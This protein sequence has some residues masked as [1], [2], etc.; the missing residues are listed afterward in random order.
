MK[1]LFSLILILMLCFH[2]F[3]GC[4]SSDSEQ[5]TKEDSS[6]TQISFA[7]SDDEMFTERDYN[8][9]YTESDCVL[10][11]LKTDS[12][13][14]SSD[15]VKISGTTITITEEAT[16]LISGSLSDGMIIIDTED[17]AK[18]HLIFN[19]VSINS[20]TSAALYVLEAEKVVVTLAPD[21]DN[22]LS[23][24]GEFT[25]ID[26]NNIDAVV[27][28][29]Q[30]LSFNGSGS[31]TITSPS[32]HGIVC[33]D[34]LVFTS[35]TYSITASSHG[36]DANDSIRIVNSNIDIEA[37]KDGIHSENDEDENLGFIYISS[38][39]LNISAEG[40]GLSAG[41]FMQ[42]VDGS[43]NVV[44][45]GGSKNA[46]TDT[47][48]SWGMH[49]GPGGPG[50][51]GGPG[52]RSQ[53]YGG[54]T[55]D[56]SE[57]TT[58][59][60]EDS[61][62][63]KGIKASGN[64]LISNGDISIDSADDSIHANTSITVNGGTFNL[65]S[66]D[67]GFHADESLTITAG[68]ININKSYE[69]L[70]AL[71]L[72]ISGGN[73]NLLASDDGLN[74]AGGTDSSGTGGPRG[75]DRFGG[76]SSS[77]GS[78]TISGGTLYVNASGDGL[79]ANGTLTISGGYTTVVGPTS[80][81]TA[82]LD[83]DTSAVIS[84]GTFIGTGSSMMAQSFSQADQGLVAISVGNQAANTNIKLVDSKNNTIIDYSPE[85]SF[86]VIILSSP[87]IISGDSYTITVGE[88]S[89]NIQAY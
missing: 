8:S 11:D 50:G 25:A 14:S 68:D 60:E 22:V 34:D 27:F 77:N 26:D 73:I 35:G 31:L 10:I 21:T 32:G 80:G 15:S 56:S 58:D 55:P 46:T 64:I 19:D 39:K 72:T 18:P 2:L 69:G 70:E 52:D 62:S 75:G 51:H 44:S 28:A 81:D 30:D 47:S 40:D 88:Y 17:T 48:S 53:G 83:Y 9:D 7:K 86:Q 38:G 89:E 85:L 66:G 16:Y 12:A 57:N 78:I 3:A 42:I 20:K 63:I 87:D 79:D 36:L 49:M 24:G 23:N 29:K 5:E 13:S 74:A 43:I 54:Y 33:K 67:D 84:G 71:N 37:N 1:K 6:S 41:V 4:S 61:T 59:S 76:S 65:S 82:T 45:G